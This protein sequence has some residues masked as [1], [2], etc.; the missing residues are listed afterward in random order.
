[1]VSVYHKKCFIPNA[2]KT[3]IFD[4][5][6]LNP[7]SQCALC[8][9]IKHSHAVSNSLSC[10]SFSTLC[11]QKLY[12]F[13]FPTLMSPHQSHKYSSSHDTCPIRKDTSPLGKSC[14]HSHL[15]SCRTTSPACLLLMSTTCTCASGTNERARNFE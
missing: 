7:F 9:S 14:T 12:F 1:M 11:L 5:L 3:S 10:G 15:Q 13:I 8:E 4:C 6:V 2:P